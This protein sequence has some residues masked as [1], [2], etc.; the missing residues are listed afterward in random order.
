MSKCLSTCATVATALCSASAATFTAGLTM[1]C[2]FLTYKIIQTPPDD[3]ALK[4][5][6]PVFTT[7]LAIASVIATYGLSK[8]TVDVLKEGCSNDDEEKQFL[9]SHKHHKNKHHEVEIV[10]DPNY[11]STSISCASAATSCAT[12]LMGCMS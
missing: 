9:A 12:A 3:P 5:I 11:T 7:F 4:I 2:S 8:L 1:G 6:V 10:V